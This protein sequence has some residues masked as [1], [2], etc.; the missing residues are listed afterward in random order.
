MKQI[1]LM[2][3]GKVDIDYSQKICSE[4]LQL[5]VDDYDHTPILKT[6]SP[7]EDVKS[8]ADNADVVLT[9]TLRRAKD[10]ANLLGVKVSE[11]SILFN[12]ASI[13]QANIPLLKLRP[14]KWLMI[15]RLLLLL[16]LGKQ[17]TSLKASKKQAKEA[18]QKLL[19]YSKE[20]RT[21]L[22]VGHGGMNWLIHKVLLK[23]GWRLNHKPSYQHWGIT[24]LVKDT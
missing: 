18:A 5:W 4:E 13:P 17:D 21:V 24:V 8:F 1:I 14:K 20:H 22:L 23:E 10:S 15:L 19:T 3:H 12:E 9:S 2:R 6:S 16:G 7:G 11:E